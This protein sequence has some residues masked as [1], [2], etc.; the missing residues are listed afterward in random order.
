MAKEFT[1]T[2]DMRAQIGRESPPWT[3]EVTTTS[4]RAFARGVGYTD[5]V[6]FDVDGARRRRLPQPAGA[7]DVSRHAGVHPRRVGRHLQRADARRAAGDQPRTQGP[8]RRRHRDRVLRPTSAPATRST[9]VSQGRRP[10]RPRSPVARQD[11]DHDQRDHLH[12]L[13]TPAKRG[14]APARPGDL[15]LGDASEGG[16]TMATHLGCDQRRRS[17]AG[18]AQAAGRAQRW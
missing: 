9:V 14:R 13:E 3:T 5:P 11:A 4:V 17:A 10:R 12:Q 7:A 8:A 6:Y 16:D 2:D 15:L 18:A 1:L